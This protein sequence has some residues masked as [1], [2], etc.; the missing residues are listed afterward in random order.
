MPDSLRRKQQT[1]ILVAVLILAA[2]G[3]YLAWPSRPKPAEPVYGGRK[4]SDWLPDYNY[5]PDSER[6]PRAEDAVRHIGTNAL[7]FLLRWTDHQDTA[8]ATQVRRA[9]NGVQ[10]ATGRGRFWENNRKERAYQAAK[11][12][13]T[14]RPEAY[15]AVPFLT[16]MFTGEGDDRKHNAA[17]ALAHMGTNGL[18]PLSA[19]LT[20]TNPD[21]RK[22]AT[23]AFQRIAAEAP[24]NSPS[25]LARTPS[26]FVTLGSANTLRASLR[27]TGRFPEPSLFAISWALVVTT[28]S[29]RLSRRVIFSHGQICY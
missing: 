7:P 28:Y 1:I 15:A 16:R 21:V 22:V 17:F 29:P 2:A 27:V 24:G 25:G 5:A 8:V 12:I 6:H 9:Y 23:N 3:L 18:A 4:L 10:H 19:A 20:N 14:L 13:L 11:A 26:T